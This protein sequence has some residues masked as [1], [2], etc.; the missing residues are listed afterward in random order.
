MLLA[1]LLLWSGI[2]AG[3]T[4]FV[5]AAYFGL[6]IFLAAI[7]PP[8]A[9]A[10]FG[11]LYAAQTAIGMFGGAGVQETTIG[12]L[13]RTAGDE[14][15]Q[16]YRDGF[17][18]FY[19]SAAAALA[20]IGSIIVG[21]GYGS[22]LTLTAIVSALFLGALNAAAV[23]QASFMRLEERHAASL[24]YSCGVPLLSC[25][26]SVTAVYLKGD[27]EAVFAGG[28]ISGLA[29][30]VF[31]RFVGLTSVSGLPTWSRVWAK[32][33]AL[34][35]FVGIALFG[36]ISGY[37]VSF[38]I[39]GIFEPIE[40][41]HYTFLLTA[42]SVAQ[43]AATAMNMTW[44]PRFYRMFLESSVEDA[45][46]H[47]RRFFTLQAWGLGLLAAVVIAALPWVARGIG[48]HLD[49]YAQM[50]L[51]LTLLFAGYLLSI[52]W[53]HAQN[54][55]L[56]ANEGTELM[57]I[58]LWTGVVGLATWIT[59]MLVLGAIGIYIGFLLQ[60]GIRSVAAWMYARTR[61]SASPP[62][63]AIA[64]AV[65]ITFVGLAAPAHAG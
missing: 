54:Y 37:G 47:S 39:D 55:F 34:L 49:A 42:A 20:A 43:M 25:A 35:P 21:G 16:L 13:R 45:E 10:S 1:R 46:M 59:S 41:A 61:W 51:E 3:A 4:A 65:A 56:V 40:V 38:F 24:A 32:A 14:R 57:R 12:Q 8:E 30:M 23:L 15:D 50:R 36:W 29:G 60:V 17:G 52:P 22:E 48:G 5:K 58:V 63:V 27:V 6:V 2:F 62:W 7:L 11:L 28:A 19:L 64:A 26:G 44:S 18:L 31:L 9:Y 53:W 33:H